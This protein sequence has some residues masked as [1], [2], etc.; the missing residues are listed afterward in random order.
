MG[1]VAFMPDTGRQYPR[2]KYPLLHIFHAS[3]QQ[4]THISSRLW[5]IT[6]FHCNS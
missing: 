5:T 1:N 4:S 6:A 2:C 3:T